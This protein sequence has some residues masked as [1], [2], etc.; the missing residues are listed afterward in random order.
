[1]TRS[2]GG[3]TME[4]GESYWIIGVGIAM[5]RGELIIFP[6][7]YFQRRPIENWRR[8]SESEWN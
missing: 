4:L 1:M 5:R 8:D 2:A 6:P 3:D 7:I